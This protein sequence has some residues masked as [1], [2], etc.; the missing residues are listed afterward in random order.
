MDNQL[1]VTQRQESY[2]DRALKNIHFDL[3][4]TNEWI[5]STIAEEDLY[6]PWTML[7]LTIP[8]ETEPDCTQSDS[9]SNLNES[10]GK[11]KLDDTVKFATVK[12]QKTKFN[13]NISDVVMANLETQ[14]YIVGFEKGLGMNLTMVQYIESEL[15]S[16][17]L[18]FEVQ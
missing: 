7:S 12:K 14:P 18:V 8:K 2:L 17:K 4:D 5:P 1:P 6:D 13:V 15:N 16:K 3:P 10:F 11:R 9:S